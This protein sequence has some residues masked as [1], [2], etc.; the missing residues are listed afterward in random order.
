MKA[1][2]LKEICENHVADLITA[3]AETKNEQRFLD[4]LDFCSRFHRYSFRN[5]ILIWCYKSD[6][7]LV[8]GFRAWQKMGRQVKKG[9]SGIPIFAP[10]AIKKQTELDEETEDGLDD[11]N[12]LRFKVVYVFDVSQTE[13]KPLPDVDTLAVCGETRLL[14][15]LENFTKAQGIKLTYISDKSLDFLNAAGVSAR[16]RIQIKSSL[17]ESQRFY[18]LSHELAHELLHDLQARRTLSTKVKELEADATAYVVSRHFGIETQSSV[19]L[20]L[21][22]VEEVDVK[23]SLDRIVSTASKIICGVHEMDKA[24]SI[25]KTVK[26]AA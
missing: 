15:G 12:F 16:G 8:A 11:K 23:E 5:R 25:N 10:M 2:E 17:N 9:A 6:A 7:T 26:E 20:A 19:Y 3:I 22:R 18:V 24:P 21:Y 4:Y 1:N 14:G 13:G